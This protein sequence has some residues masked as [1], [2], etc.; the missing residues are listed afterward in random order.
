MSLVNRKPRPLS[1]EEGSPRDTRLFIV[2]CDDTYAPQQYF[3]FFRI[4]RIQIHVVPTEDGTSAAKH[5]LNR[6]HQI[7]HEEDDE[8]WMLLDTDHCI[9]DGH[10]EGFIQALE[11]ARQTRVSVAL[12]KPCFELWLLLHHAEQSEVTQIETAK[13]AESELRKIL[14]SYNKRLLRGEHF[15]E[16]AIFPACNRARQLDEPTGDTD[17]PKTNTSRVYRLWESILSKS[18]PAQLPD[19]FRK[20]FE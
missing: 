12:S 7:E 8:L 19:S 15:P 6:L 17:R 10:F 2:A 14:G 16:E 13:D 11:E 9:N 4:P 20:F 18:T 3:N 5:V 1:R